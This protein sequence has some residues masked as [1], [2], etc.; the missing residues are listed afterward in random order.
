[1]GGRAQIPSAVTSPP[2]SSPGMNPT[3]KMGF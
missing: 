2:T 3:D 1:M